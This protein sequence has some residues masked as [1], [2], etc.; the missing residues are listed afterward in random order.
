MI[1]SYEKS[2]QSFSPASFPGFGT[3]SIP[4]FIS[5]YSYNFFPTISSAPATVI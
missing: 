4:Q 5:N 1:H 3:I 2:L